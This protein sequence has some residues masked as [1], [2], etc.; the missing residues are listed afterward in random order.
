VSARLGPSFKALPLTSSLRSSYP[1]PSVGRATVVARVANADILVV[2]KSTTPYLGSTKTWSNDYHAN[3]GVPA[4]NT[5]WDTL[6]D[7]IVNAQKASMITDQHIVEAVGYVGTST[8]SVHSKTYTTAGT[9]T[10]SGG[11]VVPIDVAALLRWATAARTSKGHP[12]YLFNYFHG[13]RSDT[14][15]RDTLHATQK[16]AIDTY[17]TAWLTGFSDG[18]NTYVRAGPRGANAT[19]RVTKTL[20]THRDFPR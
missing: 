1:V 19:A 10:V 20:L 6:F 17:A 5:A 16:T 2:I 7:A 13:I 9:L 12:I 11:S 3:G 18:T 8:V 4:S 15:D 14:S